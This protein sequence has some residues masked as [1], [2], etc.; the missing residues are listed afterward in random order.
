MDR[1]I[2]L[3]IFGICATYCIKMKRRL[4]LILFVNMNCIIND[5]KAHLSHGSF[6]EHRE[7]LDACIQDIDDMLSIKPKII[8]YDRVCNQHRDVGFFSDVSAGYKYSGAVQQSA[9]LTDNLRSLLNIVNDTFNSKFNSV[10][11]NRYND[12]DDYIS[13]HSDSEVGADMGAGVACISY[14]AERTFRIR[15]KHTKQKVVDVNMSHCSVVLMG[16]KLFQKVYTH[17]IP[18]QK[19]VKLPRYSFTFR[20]HLY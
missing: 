10:L 16:G 14:G 20:N 13:P 4:I 15:H 19:R 11:V 1:F 3:L 6:V 2:F 9:P 12:G 7:L 5:P 17:E 8:V 18:I